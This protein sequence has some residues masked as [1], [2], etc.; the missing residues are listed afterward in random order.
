[1]LDYS[2][3]ERIAIK[4]DSHI[5]EPDAIAQTDAESKPKPINALMHRVEELATRQHQDKLDRKLK[6]MTPVV[7]YVERGEK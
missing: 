4:M 7:P 1:M 2:R 6:N 5:S 3:S